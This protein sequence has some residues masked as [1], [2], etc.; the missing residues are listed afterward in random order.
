MRWI[1]SPVLAFEVY[2]VVMFAKQS[3]DEQTNAEAREGRELDRRKV[4]EERVRE[5]YK[6]A[7]PR[8]VTATVPR[9]VI[10][11]MFPFGSIVPAVNVRTVL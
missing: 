8:G 10:E 4:R 2:A 3:E 11:K 6:D 1:L 7:K 9:P 5:I